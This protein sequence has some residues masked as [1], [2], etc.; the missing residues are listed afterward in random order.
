MKECGKIVLTI[1][2][3]KLPTLLVFLFVHLVHKC[4]NLIDNI[5][6]D[7]FTPLTAKQQQKQQRYKAKAYVQNKLIT[8]N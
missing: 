4:Y 5:L 3:V 8:S 6:K 1:S 2:V 7:Y